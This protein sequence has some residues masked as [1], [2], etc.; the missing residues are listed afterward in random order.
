M[1]I[2]TL[3]NGAARIHFDAPILLV[4]QPKGFVDFRPPTVGEYIDIGDPLTWVVDENRRATPFLDRV[5]LKQWAALLMV[6][7]SFDVL[8]R[9]PSV[10][11]AVMI[12]DVITGFFQKARLTLSKQSAP[13][14]LPASA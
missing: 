2:E 6:G 13:S 10:E 12:E 14:S 7:H 8:S 5:L 3:P 1:R 4:D 11:L 9:E